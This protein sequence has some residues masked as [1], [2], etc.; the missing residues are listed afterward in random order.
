MAIKKEN[1]DVTP[2]S[3]ESVFEG[4][5]A[6]EE[7]GISFE[8]EEPKKE[9]VK[10]EVK[11]ESIPL[12][13]VQ[14]MMKEMEE[15]FT[16]QINKLKTATAKKDLDD[17]LDYV[18]ELQD[19]WLEVPVV[20]FAFSFNFSIHGDKKR[21][22]ESEPPHGAVKFK[23]LIRTKRKSGKEIQVVSVSSV[24]IQSKSV[25][26]YLRNH[27]QYGIAFYENMESAMNIDSTWAQKM[28]EAQ[29]SIGRLSDMQVIARAKQEGISVSQSPE[30]MRRELVE[31]TAKRAIAQQ[32]RLLYGGLKKATIDKGTD[33]SIIEKTIA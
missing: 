32:E 28:V 5:N 7:S 14:K 4:F 26:D 33:R 25:V 3:E 23:P 2:Q 20:F 24:K 27:S 6:P 18:S 13:F 16:A 31:V 15:K 11:E 10:Q 9:E 12:S 19:D 1:K 22:I 29:Q 30:R 8:I 17:D 21:G